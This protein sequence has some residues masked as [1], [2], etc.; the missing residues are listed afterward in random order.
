[1]AF[2]TVLG[3][4]CRARARGTQGRNAVK[5]APGGA[6]GVAAAP[7]AIIA[8]SAGLPHAEMAGWSRIHQGDDMRYALATCLFVMAG[9]LAA[10]TSVDVL[11]A[12]Q[13]IAEGRIAQALA[14]LRSEAEAGDPLAQSL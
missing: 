5:S 7:P 6:P 10:Q 2:P 3:L 4:P 8:A 11:D 13:A 1:M 12:R 9:P 14:V